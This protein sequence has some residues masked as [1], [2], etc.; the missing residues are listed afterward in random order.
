MNIEVKELVKKYNQEHLLKFYDELND[1]EKENLIN[2][3]KN[4]DFEQMKN[5]YENSYIDEVLDL[6]KISPLKIIKKC[7]NSEYI[8][9]GKE[10][11]KNSEYAIVIMAGGKASRLGYNM[12][13][14][15]L[16]I[17]INGKS[18]SL[19]EHFINQ[20]KNVYDEFGIYTNLYIMTNDE[21]DSVIKDF[22]KDNN[23]FDYNKESIHFFKQDNLPI[24][25]TKGKLLLSKKNEILK[26]PNGNGDI[27]EALKR[28]NMIDDMENKGIKYILFSTT[29]N[30]LANL[31][32]YNLIGATII[33]NYNVTTKT[34][35][36]KDGEKDW[37]FCKYNNKPFI[38]PSSY[39]TE[40]INNKKI[41]GDYVYR[42]RNIAYHLV[43][44]NS[45][46]KYANISLP[47]HRA[48]K[49]NNYLDEFGNM[50]IA[51]SNNSFKFEKFI[52]DAFYYDDDML[53]YRAD[54]SEFFPIKTEEDLIKAENILNKNVIV[55]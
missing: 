21:Y 4:V 41:D 55:D 3:I 33:N 25:D 15:C 38:L 26:G 12:P 35:V 8:N 7:K 23:Y 54:E 2:E 40:D 52:F 53:L 34:L 32:D 5:I 6:N 39:I 46:K 51:E 27:F 14:G 48:Y 9:K 13:K 31:F 20:L 36:K 17:N 22:F 45:V 50:I 10:L 30:I 24:L 29:D 44:L 1:K 19:F 42:E 47:Y 18:T 28:Y 16:K 49:K 37:A 43:S 11:V